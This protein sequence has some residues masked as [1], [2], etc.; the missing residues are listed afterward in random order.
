M[1]N[2]ETNAI[3]ISVL[4]ETLALLLSKSVQPK[5]GVITAVTTDDTLFAIQNTAEDVRF[6]RKA[7]FLV[8][9][10]GDIR[11][12]ADTGSEVT[13]VGQICIGTKTGI[14]GGSYFIGLVNFY[15]PTQ[16]SHITF[17]YQLL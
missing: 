14:N 8:A 13:A 6:I 3:E 16:D 12:I 15:P 10:L 9:L 1:A 17:I 2:V 5:D 7:D 4:K 11:K